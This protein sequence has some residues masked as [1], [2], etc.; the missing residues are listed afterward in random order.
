MTGTMCT[1]H[2]RL[3][4]PDDG[5]GLVL[6]SVSSL[7]MAEGGAGVVVHAGKSRGHDG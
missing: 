5:C 6:R 4:V 3:T 2:G 1:G 7:G